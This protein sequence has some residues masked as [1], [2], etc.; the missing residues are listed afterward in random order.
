MTDAQQR[1]PPGA[2]KKEAVG[3]VKETVEQFK[4]APATRRKESEQLSKQAETAPDVKETTEEAT[5]EGDK[6]VA[7]LQEGLKEGEKPPEGLTK[8]EPEPLTE[9]EKSRLTPGKD[10]DIS[11]LTEQDIPKEGEEALKEGEELPK[12]SEATAEG[13]QEGKQVPK[14]GEEALK[15]G[16]GEIGKEGKDTL[17]KGE[18]VPKE[19]EGLLEEGDEKGKQALNEGD[20]VPKEGEEA[21][22]EGEEAVPTEELPDLSILKG[23]KVNKAGNVVNKDDEIVGRIKEGVIARLVGRRVDENGDIW[24]DSGKKIG[25][26]ELIPE[27]EREAML[28][29]PA[30]FEPF[31]DAVVDGE[32]YVIFN[33]ERVGKVVEGDIKLLRGMKVDQEG[34]ILNRGGNVVGRAERWEPEP[35]PELPPEPE[36]DRSILAG[37]RVNKVGNVVDNSGTIYGRV[38][39]GDPK[40]MA[41]RM[42]DKLGNILS[43]SGDII[44][45]AEVVPEGERAGL[46]EG[47]FAELSGCTV[48]KDGKVVTPGGDVVGRLISGDP[49]SLFG[50]S[51]DE[52]GDIC[53]KNG[54]V[55]GKAE[56]W[57]EEV[58][59]KKKNPM[60]GRRVNR[61]GNVVDEDGNIVGKLT[62]GELSICAGQDI[63]DDG[64]VVDT[65]GTTIGHVS[66]IQ[67][68]PEPKESPEDKETREQAE[69]DKKLAQQMAFCLT[70]VVD[71]IKPICEMITRVKFSR[72]L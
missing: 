16:E 5:K 50:R 63:D 40:S 67:D 38:I 18:E 44:G 49:K 55:L 57:E 43:E 36:V 27:E 65:K 69:K 8:V 3:D 24:D 37:K 20:E 54:N 32:G 33:G 19:G 1:A 71:K 66:L 23:G 64:D 61:E 26:A 6:P 45:K 68:I 53:D 72:L 47:P 51:V 21:V 39:E 2:A 42:C 35:E 7:E 46:K 41:G 25:V 11:Q 4:D 70:Q 12:D 10:V 62:T 15:E 60:S 56:R 59:E 22:K 9:E 31:P 58:V 17:Q 34:D 52:D 28:K 14:Q 29:E 13:L 30:P 48:S